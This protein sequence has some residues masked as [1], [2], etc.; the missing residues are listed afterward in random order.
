MNKTYVTITKFNTEHKATDV[1]A[2]SIN[3]SNDEMLPVESFMPMCSNFCNA[4]YPYV[5]LTIEPFGKMKYD[6]TFI[7]SKFKNNCI[8]TKVE[9][10]N[11]RKVIE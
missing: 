4:N 8:H 2:M 6:I 5:L 9:T 11:I 3:S 10:V 1:I 7:T